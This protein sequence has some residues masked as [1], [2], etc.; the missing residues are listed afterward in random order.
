MVPRDELKWFG[1]SAPVK[2]GSAITKTEGLT[3]LGFPIV[4]YLRYGNHS[5]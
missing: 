4:L 5:S 1:N 2:F 3:K